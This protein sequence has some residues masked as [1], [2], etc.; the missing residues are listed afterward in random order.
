MMTIKR[1]FS[2]GDRIIIGDV[3]GDVY[4]ITLTHIYPDEVGAGVSSGEVTGRNIMVP[5]YL[6]FENNITNYTL[7]HD[8]VLSSMDISITY[9]SDLDRA[10]E[11]IEGVAVKQIAELKEKHKEAPYTRISMADSS[12]IVS[13]K[14]YVPVKQL[15]ELKSK[16][17]KEVYDLIKKEKN[18]EIAYPHTTVIFKDKK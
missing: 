11:I 3:R 14:F 8:F 7:T 15:M 6:F 1:P 5:N 9:E 16:I 4:D 13:L 17:T 18:V 10:I 2:I 12:M